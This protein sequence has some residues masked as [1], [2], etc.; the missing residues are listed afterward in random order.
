MADENPNARLIAMTD[1]V[2]GIAMTLLVLDVQLPGPA[3]HLDNAGLWQALLQIRP[4]ISS[5]CISFLVI[6]VLWLTHVQKFRH[7]RQGSALL[8]WLHI[9]FLLLV[10]FVP[11]TTSVLAESGNSLATALYALVMGAASA[12]LGSM[13]VHVQMSGVTDE[14]IAQEQLHAVTLSQFGSAI[15]FFVSAAMAFINA[16]AAK[17]FWL[18]LIPMGFIRRRN[19]KQARNGQD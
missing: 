9:A 19:I 14:T 1:A 17:L 18:L 4:Q 2:L 3:E 13:S 11:F 12:L 16:D 8:N 6:A 7:V 15:V 10:G 5:Y